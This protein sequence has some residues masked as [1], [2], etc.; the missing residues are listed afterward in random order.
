M[1]IRE[2]RYSAGVWLDRGKQVLRFR[3]ATV[4]MQIHKLVQR[5][6]I[7]DTFEVGMLYVNTV[8]EEL[9]IGY[10]PQGLS[11]LNTHP[12]IICIMLDTSEIQ[13]GEPKVTSR[14]LSKVYPS[15]YVKEL[16]SV[17]TQGISKR[18]LASNPKLVSEILSANDKATFA[19]A[20]R[21]YNKILG[22]V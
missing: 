20:V 3:K 18:M 7:A 11:L 21:I 19:E 9:F 2:L 10:S 1:G 5:L 8:T 22:S 14:I 6:W 4:L 16:I 15:Y 17:Y 13:L 12:E